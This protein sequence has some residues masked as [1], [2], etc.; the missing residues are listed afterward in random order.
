MLTTIGLPFYNNETTL[1]D[2]IRSVFA[3]TYE[4]WEL[5]LVDDGSTDGS[6]SIARSI[7]DPRVRVVSDGVNLKLPARLNQIAEMARGDFVA[8]FDGDDM[9][10]PERLGYQVEFLI[11]HPDIDIVSSGEW[12]ITEDAE[13]YGIRMPELTRDIRT[14]ILTGHFIS[15]PTVMGRRS[16][17]RNHRYDESFARTQD[18]E[19]WCRTHRSTRIA[20]LSKPLL[21]TRD[22]QSASRRRYID[23]C[24][25]GRRVLNRYAVPMVGIRRAATLLARSYFKEIVAR[26]AWSLCLDSMMTRHRSRRLTST[27]RAEV[28]AIIRA[29]QAVEVPG[30]D[31]AT[32]GL[33][34]GEGVS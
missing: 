26:S 28:E 32:P 15:H 16:W 23:S 2:A 17:F 29:V 8:R 1:A 13:P 3:Q 21:L 19:L 11:G 20:R 24:R 5:I 30:V 31:E 27:Q 25:S 7:C 9:M 14:T 18:T 4:E 34:L 33:M 12:T 6:L 22:V 10:H